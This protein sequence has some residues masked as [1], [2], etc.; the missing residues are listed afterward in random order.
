ME[1]TNASILTKKNIIA[2]LIIGIILLIIPV[3]VK[4]VS[5]RQLL[6][7]RAAADPITF[8]GPDVSSDKTTTNSTTVTVE[9]RSP[10]GP[11]VSSVSAT[12]TP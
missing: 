6:R 2:I 10:L 8:T 11:P 12:P 3:G 4:L 1:E 7:S 5:E 9:L